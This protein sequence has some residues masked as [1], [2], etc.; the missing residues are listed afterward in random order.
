VTDVL[1]RAQRAL[2]EL[3]ATIDPAE[4]LRFAIRRAAGGGIESLLEFLASRVPGNPRSPS[5]YRWE[6]CHK[7][8]VRMP[9]YAPS[10][11]AWVAWRAGEAAQL[12]RDPWDVETRLLLPVILAENLGAL[13]AD[14][15][16]QARALL[17]EAT[18]IARRDVARYIAVND[19]WEDTWALWCITRSPRV[20]DHLHPLA[21][22]LAITYAAGGRV[23]QCGTKFPYYDKP[24]VTASAQLASSLLA[25]GSDLELAARLAAFVRDQRRPSGGWGDDDEREDPLTTLVAADLLARTDPSV[26]VGPTLAYFEATQHADGLWRALGPDAPWL[27]AEVAL[28]IEL[29]QRPFSERFRWPHYGRSLVDQKTGVPFFAHFLDIAKLLAALPGLAATPVE[30]AFIDLIGF[31][32]FNNRYGQD[33]GDE[34]LQLFATE[35]ATVPSA[36]VVR[37]GGD[38]F[39]VIGAPARA[40]LLGD[41]RTFMTAW[42]A[43]FH[44]RFGADVP[45]VLPRVVVGVAP[46]GELRALRQR[47]GR[48]ITALKELATIPETG[49]VLES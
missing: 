13:L 18:P 38:E 8:G 16:E 6:L 39:L 10:E 12:A 30:L 47:L 3:D 45:A 27:T 24:L 25:L 1:G 36:R 9:P 31:R 26:D 48:E 7:V 21:V 5:R 23:P 42:K 32:A 49:V 41:L 19:A 4:P 17:A 37:D 34:V 11:R 14:P 15:S 43:C 35:L 2:A 44:R 20:L 22:A 40:R 29:A 33:A 28:V 46:G